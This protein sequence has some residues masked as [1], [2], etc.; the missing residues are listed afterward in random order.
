MEPVKNPILQSSSGLG[1]ALISVSICNFRT[2]YQFT[3]S[4]VKIQY[5]PILIKNVTGDV[6]TFV[7]WSLRYLRA[8]LTGLSEG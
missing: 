6:S 2:A 5:F 4:H 7:D 3:Q 8:N 1:T